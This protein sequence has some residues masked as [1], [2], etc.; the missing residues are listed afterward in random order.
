M[1]DA[2]KLGQLKLE[3]RQIQ[4]GV[5]TAGAR[6]RLDDACNAIQATIE[7]LT[8]ERRIALVRK[9]VTQP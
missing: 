3:L 7:I 4:Q 2:V 5:T 8:E 6:Q 1:R 9:P